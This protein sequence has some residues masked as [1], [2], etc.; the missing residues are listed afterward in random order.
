ML[1]LEREYP[2]LISDCVVKKPCVGKDF[3]LMC[4]SVHPAVNWVPVGARWPMTC[5][6]C[7][8]NYI[9]LQCILTGGCLMCEFLY[10]GLKSAE[11]PV[12]GWLSDYKLGY[13]G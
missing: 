6:S 13:Y 8:I 3:N 1:N 9:K 5:S 7:T 11:Q 10:Q 2:G 12:K 4:A